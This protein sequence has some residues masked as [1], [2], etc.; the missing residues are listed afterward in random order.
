MLQPLGVGRAQQQL[1][2]RAGRMISARIALVHGSNEV[3][4]LA[5]FE[6]MLVPMPVRGALLRGRLVSGLPLS[7]HVNA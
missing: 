7:V 1:D 6:A 5:Q 4:G 2:N 3:G